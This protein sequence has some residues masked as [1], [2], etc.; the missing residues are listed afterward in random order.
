[1]TKCKMIVSFTL[2]IMFFNFPLFFTTSSISNNNSNTTNSY[3]RVEQTTILQPEIK[4]YRAEIHWVKTNIVLDSK[5]LGTV[6]ILVNCTPEANHVGLLLGNFVENEI[7]EFNLGNSKA[8]TAGYEIGLNVSSSGSREYDYIFY[9][10][11]TTHVNISES[12]LYEITY[13]GNFV[14]SGQIER[15]QVNPELAII[16]L[17]RPLWNITIPYQELTVVLPVIVDGGIVTPQFLNDIQF[18]VSAQMST[19]DISYTTINDS[20]VDLLVFNCSKTS[21]G[22]KAPFEATF[23][24][25]LTYFSLP[26]IMNWLVLLFVFIFIAGALVLFFVIIDVRN[27]TETE[28]SEFKEDLYELLKSNEK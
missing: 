8:K 20:G 26:N 9:L 18:N 27:K 21:M 2:I 23:Y 19:Y 22:L 6:T 15:F 3:N 10:S 24:L 12:I 4:E 25:S 11:E 5:G 13:T 7:T 28:I 16:N 17:N 1:M 14:L